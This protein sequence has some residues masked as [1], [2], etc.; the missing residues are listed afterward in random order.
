MIE[1]QSFVPN[2]KNDLNFQTIDHKTICANL[3]LR[4]DLW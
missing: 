1:D 2:K 3:L 4:N